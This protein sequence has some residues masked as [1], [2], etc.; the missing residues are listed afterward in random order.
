MLGVVV[1]THGHL[2]EELVQAARKIVG[3][4]EGLEAVSI[5]WDDNVSGASVTIEGA[6]RR[7]DRGSGVIV[8]TDMFGG[9]PTNLALAL[10]E[11]DKVEIVTGANLPML[12]KCTNVR[13][14]MSLHETAVQIADEARA[15]IQIAGEVLHA[16]AEGEE[17]A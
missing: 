8:L 5:G 2:A 12:I 6:V 15:A 10:L 11:P 14:E 13:E 4:V 7:V 16:P 1:V 17:S 9:T 3:S